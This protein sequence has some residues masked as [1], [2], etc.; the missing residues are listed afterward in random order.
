[1]AIDMACG[2][3]VNEK[4]PPRGNELRRKGLLFLRR[5]LQ[6][7]FGQRACEVFSGG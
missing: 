2:K 3:I 5:L 6:T 7:G 1:M 4:S